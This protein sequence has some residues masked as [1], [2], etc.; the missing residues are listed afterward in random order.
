MAELW[1][2]ICGLRDREAIDA[3]AAAQV[4]AVGF[5]FHEPSPRNVSIAEARGL[6]SCVPCGI[7]RVAVFLRPSQELI[8]SVLEALQPDWVQVDH[9]DLERL[10]LPA[11]QRVLPVLRTHSIET[12]LTAFPPL[13]LVEGARSGA[14]RKADWTEGG[15]LARLTRVVLAGGLDATNVA[16]A[17]RVVR[18]YGVD[19][20]SGVES[21]P[22]VKDPV[23]IREFV[24][25][26]RTA[27]ARL[28]GGDIQEMQR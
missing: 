7:D 2:K 14:G 15:R 5:V 6:R 3:A 19:A 22:G 12:G 11:G 10:V 20:S 27:H 1:V 25:A 21:A 23:R 17:I 13:V 28:A 16:E 4:Q 26:A 24:T 18:P 8:D 9:G